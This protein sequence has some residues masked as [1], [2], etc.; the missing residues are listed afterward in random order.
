[1]NIWQQRH[2]LPV[3]LSIGV[4]V[5][6]AGCSEDVAVDPVEDV[7][8]T[9][10]TSPLSDDEVIDTFKEGL[11]R[12]HT[13]NLTNMQPETVPSDI[14]ALSKFS[15]KDIA[16]AAQDAVIWHRTL[17]VNPALQGEVTTEQLQAV[18]SDTVTGN[19]NN[20]IGK[21]WDNRTEWVEA[22]ATDPSLNRLQ[23]FKF[24]SEKYDYAVDIPTKKD[25]DLYQYYPCWS[26]LS[27]LTTWSLFGG[28]PVPGTLTPM[29]PMPGSPSGAFPEKYTWKGWN[30][31]LD[32]ANAP[33]TMF[34]TL[35]N[36]QWRYHATATYGS[37]LTDDNKNIA[38]K[39]KKE[40]QF[41]HP[42]FYY[43]FTAEQGIEPQDIY[44][45]VTA[46]VMLKMVRNEQSGKNKPRWLVEDA[47]LFYPYT[48][49]EGYGFK[50][51]L[52]G[53]DK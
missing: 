37:L 31:Q 27:G 51:G 20:W 45:E 12:G 22:A 39:L 40:Q 29:Q 11:N 16:H 10:P 14:E 6:L 46:D 41:T 23:G 18:N 8:T 48:P 15:R 24:D 3:A 47:F 52:V 17:A 49:D 26:K 53:S 42:M 1:M 5:L 28:D 25:K 7:V 34:I 33:D 2:V 36:L 38:S 44:V 9:Q 13:L 43:Y 4:A 19:M 30:A 32:P 50:A 35:D 21:C